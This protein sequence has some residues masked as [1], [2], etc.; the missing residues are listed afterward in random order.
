[1]GRIALF[2]LFGQQEV[3][4]AVLNL[5]SLPPFPPPSKKMNDHEQYD[6]CDTRAGNFPLPPPQNKLHSDQNPQEFKR[7]I[8]K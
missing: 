4:S 2:A 3:F 8:M 5:L 7:E 1:M 6:E